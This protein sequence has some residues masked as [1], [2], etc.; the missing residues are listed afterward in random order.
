MTAQRRMC[1]L[2][3]LNL[4][5]LLLQLGSRAL[6][7]VADSGVAPVVRGRALE[8]LD[9]RGQVRASIS[10]M[11]ADPTVKMPD[12]RAVGPRDWRSFSDDR[13]RLS[14]RGAPGARSC[15]PWLRALRVPPSGRAGDRAWA[16]STRGRCR[17][18]TDR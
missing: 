7:A 5:L 6:P 10:V 18:T 17:L 11:P 8:I 14:N 12:G 2:T 4:G 1:A 13:Q 3:G 15:P 9:E 16:F